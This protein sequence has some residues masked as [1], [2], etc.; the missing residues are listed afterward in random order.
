MAGDQRPAGEKAERPST[1]NLP[2]HIHRLAR[3]AARLV[4]EA[5]GRPYSLTQ[6]VTEALL[7]RIK[8]IID[9]YNDGRP[10]F[11]DDKPLPPGRT[12]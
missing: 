7:S 8:W 9:T 3:A 11:P 4:S 2:R 6:L 10:L 5:T 12:R 1:I